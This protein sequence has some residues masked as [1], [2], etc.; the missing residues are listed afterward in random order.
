MATPPTILLPRQD[1]IQ[2][3][4]NLDPK[5]VGLAEKMGNGKRT[6]SISRRDGPASK[7]GMEASTFKIHNSRCNGLADKW[8]QKETQLAFV[9]PVG[10]YRRPT[11]Q[12]VGWTVTGP[13]PPSGC[14]LVAGSFVSG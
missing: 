8:E 4:Q 14:V 5:T 10:L 11:P 2:A 13:S 12:W 3:L 7:M 6:F 9:L 1:D